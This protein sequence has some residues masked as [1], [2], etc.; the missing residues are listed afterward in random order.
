MRLLPETRRGKAALLGG[1]VLLV[2]T[3]AWALPW[4]VDMVDAVTLKAYEWHMMTPPEGT[5][6]TN[7]WHKNYER[8]SAVGQALTDPYPV[9]EERIAHGKVL[10]GIYCAACHGDDG[11]GGAPVT[12][13]DPAH[14]K[15]RYPIP[16]PHLSGPGAISAMRTDGWIYLV[17]R[18]GGAIMPSYS[19][20]MSDEEMW[21]VVEYIRTLPGAKYTPPPAPQ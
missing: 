16:P 1:V 9:N 20:A 5:V 2:S 10:F 19:Y 15:K 21:D 13:N 8:T 17:I 11:L 7:R 6:S 3:A 18:N 4:D 12:D 14:G